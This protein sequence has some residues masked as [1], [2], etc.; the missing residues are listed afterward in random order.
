MEVNSFPENG[1][2][3]FQV[4]HK[5]SALYGGQGLLLGLAHDFMPDRCVVPFS[6]CAHALMAFARCGVFRKSLFVLSFVPCRDVEGIQIIMGLFILFVL[7]VDPILV[8]YSVP[9]P[10]HLYDSGCLLSLRDNLLS[11]MTT[12]SRF[13]ILKS[14]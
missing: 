6:F 9:V 3:P 10:I 14:V 8:H 13:R 2:P 5:S 4:L 12:E 7:R 11:C 1:L